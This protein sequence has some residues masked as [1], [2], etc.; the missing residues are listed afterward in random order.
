MYSCI[1]VS[2]LTHLE[3]VYNRLLL[4]LEF[5]YKSTVSL[6]YHICRVSKITGV[7]FKVPPVLFVQPWHQRYF[8]LTHHQSCLFACTIYPPSKI[9]NQFHRSWNRLSTCLVNII[10]S[11]TCF[12]SGD[13]SVHVPSDLL[14]QQCDVITRSLYLHFQLTCHRSLPCFE[15]ISPEKIKVVTSTSSSD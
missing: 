10:P 9:M 13:L 4:G 1:L 14:A 6:R 7:F 11:K 3:K 8:A 15:V 5:P 12:F 2:N